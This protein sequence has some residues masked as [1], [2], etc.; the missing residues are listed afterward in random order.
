MVINQGELGKQ[1]ILQPAS[2][3]RLLHADVTDIAGDP[4]QGYGIL[5][6]RVG[7]L[8]GHGGSDVGTSTQILVDPTAGTGVVL[9]ANA[10]SE[11]S[12]PEWTTG[13][14]PILAR[15]LTHV[16]SCP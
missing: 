15:L 13:L 12:D 16:Q 8:A 3:Q 1:R 14:G 2:V 6:D 7:Q 10:D 4:S 9:L 5:W 11:L